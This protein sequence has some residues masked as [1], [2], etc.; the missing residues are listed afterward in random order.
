MTY[1]DLKTGLKK[2]Q[3]ENKAWEQHAKD[4]LKGLP[5]KEEAWERA[6]KEIPQF[7]YAEFRQ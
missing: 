5:T 7:K 2:T 3:E 6:E 1:T 4:Q